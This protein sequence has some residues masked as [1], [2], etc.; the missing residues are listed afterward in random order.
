MQ[1][2]AAHCTSG[3]HI[4]LAS[5]AESSTSARFFDLLSD[6]LVAVILLRV[7]LGDERACSNSNKTTVALV[8]KRFR[9]VVLQQA[10]VLRIAHYPKMRTFQQCVSL[11]ELHLCAGALP[12]L[13]FITHAS[14]LKALT[15]LTS[16]R[17]DSDCSACVPPDM[18]RIARAVA[19]PSSLRRLSRFSVPTVRSGVFYKLVKSLRSPLRYL[20]GTSRETRAPSSF[21]LDLPRLPARAV[22]RS[23]VTL[24]LSATPRLR[25]LKLDGWHGADDMLLASLTK[26]SA[27]ESI[28]LVGIRKLT[29]NSVAQL[30]PLARRLRCLNLSLCQTLSSSGIQLLPGAFL[31]DSALPKLW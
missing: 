3:R 14:D 30:L 19:P 10:R 6:D 16:L 31:L 23:D 8:C 4:D 18:Q 21:E 15:T 22:S 7:N 28:S 5:A 2:A 20:A 13:L 26:L 27:L 17:V 1:Y 9:S 25:E 29:D 12:L 24:D 11:Q